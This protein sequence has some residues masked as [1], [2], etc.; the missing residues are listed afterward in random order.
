MS[1]HC[2]LNQP[3]RGTSTIDVL[4]SNFLALHQIVSR[5]CFVRDAHKTSGT[6]NAIIS[7]YITRSK[8]ARRLTDRPFS[9]SGLLG[10]P[11]ECPAAAPSARAYSILPTV[12][13]PTEAERISAH[14]A[15][16]AHVRMPLTPS[17]CRCCPRVVR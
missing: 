6:K 1:L 9:C 17:A 14:L 5:N 13:D 2:H 15:E 11:M 8:K 3:L 10:L 7:P 12:A 4:T 16:G